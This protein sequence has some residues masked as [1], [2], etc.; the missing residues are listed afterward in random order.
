MTNESTVDN[1][2]DHAGDEQELMVSGAERPR[3]RET[4][5]VHASKQRL[6][7]PATAENGNE[8]RSPEK[9]LLTEN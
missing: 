9:M 7:K 1:P 4:F 8:K 2:C 6:L 3:A 5:T